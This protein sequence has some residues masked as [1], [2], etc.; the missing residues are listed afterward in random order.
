MDLRTLRAFV[1]VIRLGG[2]SRAAKAVFTTQ[3]TVSK[4]VKQ[5]EE[6][7]GLPLVDRTGARSRPTAAGEIVY[8][9]AVAM[10][11]ERDD[12]LAELDELRGLKRGVLRLGLPPIGSNTLFAPLFAVYRSRYPGVEI[13]LLEHGSKRLAELL[14]AGDID[15]GA[16]LLPI[17]D[18]LEWQDVHREPIVAIVPADHPLA[19]RAQVSLAELGSLPFILFE[20]GFALNA[21]I[22]D[23]CRR[24]AVTPQVAARS[25]Q[26]EFILELIAAGLG[27]GFLPRMMFESRGHSRVR[28]ITISDPGMIWHMALAWRRGGYLGEAARAWLQLVQQTQ[29]PPIAGRD[30]Y[31][32]AAD[33]APAGGE[34]LKDED[35]PAHR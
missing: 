5:L 29:M 26:I 31:H 12:L 10:L 16:L 21:I 17:A 3:S 14:R 35:D 18:D 32:S 20:A 8:R 13:R 15:L 19:N 24:C 28:S 2:F 25:S 1:E 11:A 27:V 30:A 22:Q 6:E 9:R 4:A 34:R 7:L 23:A 33:R